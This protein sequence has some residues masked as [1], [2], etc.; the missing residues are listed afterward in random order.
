[1]KTQIKKLLVVFLLVFLSFSSLAG[2]VSLTAA[3]SSGIINLQVQGNQLIE[4]RQVGVYQPSGPVIL[5]GLLEGT[6]AFTANG[7]GSWML[8]DGTQLF[9]TW[10]T[11]GINGELDSMLA[12]N[13]TLL[14]IFMSTAQWLAN[15]GNYQS[16]IH[17]I[18][19]Q[20]QN[21]G[22]IADLVFWD[23]NVTTGTEIIVNPWE[24]TGNGAINST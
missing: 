17:Y 5:K 21:R 6:L 16:N 12:F 8:P 3:Q 4:T 18:V 2:M 9:Q 22:I 11:A 20:C 15:T 19:S 13:A 7:A 24:D 10:S 1:M 14:R 23:N